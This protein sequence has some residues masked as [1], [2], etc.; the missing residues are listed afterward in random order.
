MAEAI[1]DG[2]GSGYPAQVNYNNEL[3]VYNTAALDNYSQL[4]SYTAGG[5]PEYIG[6]AVPG[7]NSGTALWQIK[8]LGYNASNAVEW[9]GFADGNSKF[10]N[11]WTNKATYTYS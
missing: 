1:I 8:K 2:I 11:I 3:R 6:L 10:D 7:T 9:I 5:L 4:L